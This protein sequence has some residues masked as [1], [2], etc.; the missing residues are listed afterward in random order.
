VKAKSQSNAWFHAGMVATFVAMFAVLVNKR[1]FDPPIYTAVLALLMLT[2]TVL[3]WWYEARR[4]QQLD[5]LELASR[6]FGARWSTAVLG[7]VVLLLLFVTPVQDAIVRF[8]EA[9]EDHR[10]R[11]LP[12]PVGVFTFGFVVA[13][14]VQMASKSVLGSVWTWTKR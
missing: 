8:A 12:A 9:Y 5:E 3:A 2:A 1:A 7:F 4:E 14:F 10:T 13:M 6:S 11:P